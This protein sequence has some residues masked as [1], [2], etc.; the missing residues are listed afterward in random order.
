MS[1]YYIQ[2]F[3]TEITGFMTKVVEVLWSDPAH[4]KHGK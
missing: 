3:F 1:S 2:H 4:F